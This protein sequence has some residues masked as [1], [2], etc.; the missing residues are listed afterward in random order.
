MADWVRR[1]V[2]QIWIV[3]QDFEGSSQRYVSFFQ[4]SL[5]EP[6][7]HCRALIVEIYQ[8]TVSK[9]GL[10]TKSISEQD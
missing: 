9:D 8:I 7:L 5:I 4:I 6:A 3:F 2:T 10:H 1:M